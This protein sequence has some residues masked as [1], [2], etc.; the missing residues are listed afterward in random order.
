MVSV[1]EIGSLSEIPANKN[2]VLVK[3][4][5]A[6]KHTR[7]TRGLTIEVDRQVP[8]ELLEFALTSEIERAK[9]EAEKIGIQSV[10][11]IRG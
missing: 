9:E 3:F 10:F 6:N 5:K 11:I 8:K 1:I 2:R 4:G 7:H